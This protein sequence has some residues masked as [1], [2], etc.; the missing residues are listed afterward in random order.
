[1]KVYDKY[2]YGRSCYMPPKRV[3]NVRSFPFVN[4]TI[5]F[6]N[7]NGVTV[8]TIRVDYWDYHEYSNILNYIK[9]EC[10]IINNVNINTCYEILLA[11]LRRT[12]SRILC[13]MSKIIDWCDFDISYSG[14]VATLYIDR[15]PINCLICL[16]PDEHEFFEYIETCDLNNLSNRPLVDSLICYLSRYIERLEYYEQEIAKSKN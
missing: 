1:M 16:K 14:S 3:D 10:A 9:A 6:K 15:C 8:A 5:R 13:V 11:V 7:H 4:K 12:V 2:V